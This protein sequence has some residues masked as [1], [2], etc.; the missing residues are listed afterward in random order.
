MAT[1]ELK[2]DGKVLGIRPTSIPHGSL[3]AL[4]SSQHFHHLAT[5]KI[6]Q[7]IHSQDFREKNVPNIT[8]EG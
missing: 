7:L 4:G 2:T 8:L 1:G 3:V 5:K 6:I